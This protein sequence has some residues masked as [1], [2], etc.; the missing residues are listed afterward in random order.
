MN[1][2]IYMKEALKL[3][4]IAY[5]NDEVPIGAV[6]VRN[7]VIIGKGYNTKNG[8]KDATNHA[9]IIAIREACKVVGDW[10]LTDCILFTTLEPCPM[11][12]G[13]IK[14]SRIKKVIISANNLK[15]NL[16]NNAIDEHIE[17][18]DNILKEESLILLQKFFKEKRK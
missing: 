17:I 8:S 7:N 3:A 11:C 5:K 13:A 10:R 2:N 6:V 4:K 9:E 12:W 14:E 18:V 1:Y 16:K 15:E